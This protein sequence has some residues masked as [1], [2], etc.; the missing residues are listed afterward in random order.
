M[1]ILKNTAL[2]LFALCGFAQSSHSDISKGLTG[3]GLNYPGISFKYFLNDRT[4]LEVKA[5][6]EQGA[7]AVGARA[8]R[9]LKSYSSVYLFAGGEL[10]MLTFE[11]EVG[12]GSGRVLAVFAGGEFF[13]RDNISLQLDLGP[14]MLMLNDNKYEV[15]ESG[16]E[17]ILNIGVN[18]YFN[19][20]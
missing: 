15:S 4:E 3:A 19:P 8:Y 9:F 11:G 12:R 2:L 18:W 14:A 17:L 20:K 6:S 1:K 5:Q 10:D 13:F 7:G 16:L